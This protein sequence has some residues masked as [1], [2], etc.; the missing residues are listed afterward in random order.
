[1][2]TNLAVAGITACSLFLTSAIRHPLTSSGRRLQL[3]SK[4]W[5]SSMEA[6]FARRR[7]YSCW[8]AS[9][10][11]ARTSRKLPTSCGMNCAWHTTTTSQRSGFYKTRVILNEEVEVESITEKW[12]ALLV[13]PS[14]CTVCNTHVRAFMSV[15]NP[16]HLFL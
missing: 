4:L 9:E 7:Q 8:P 1:M 10:G 2:A 12:P 6:S 16:S 13:R 5:P 15:S 14:L 3:H 11:R